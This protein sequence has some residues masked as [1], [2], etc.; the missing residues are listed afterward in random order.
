MRN[1]Y[2]KAHIKHEKKKIDNYWGL[3]GA[4]L[5]KSCLKSLSYNA[6]DKH[7]SL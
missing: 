1:I 5:R 7:L 3:F 4:P 6:F 2:F